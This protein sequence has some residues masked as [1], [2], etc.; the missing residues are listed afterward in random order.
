MGGYGSGRWG[1]GGKKTQVEE[2]IKW[3]IV[4]LKNYL[5]PGHWGTT[6]WM[7][8][9]RESGS[10]SFRVLG[11]EEPEAL[12]VSYTIG[13]RSGNPQD[14][15]YRVNLTTTPLPWGGVRYWFVCPLQGCGRRV[16]CLYLPPGSK[17]FG[18]R[19]CYDLSYESQQ[20]GNWS[21]GFYDRMALEMSGNYPGI[22]GKDVKTL[23]DGKQ[24][25]NLSSLYLEKALSHLK[26]YDRYEGYLSAEELC[27]QSG[28]TSENLIKLEETRL[29]VPDTK[30]GR[31]RPKLVGWGKK[32]AYLL[33]EG[34]GIEEIKIWS[35]ERWKSKNP[36]EWPP[37]RRVHDR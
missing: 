23:L 7:I 25:R 19:H 3:R 34:W 6:R 33:G 24:S 4:G 9:E 29:L 16:G 18:C 32:L 5:N 15:K 35:K 17:Y 2:C 27:Q 26:N 37:K 1:W 8:G 36:R 10:I 20:D 28:L 13:A 12:Q 14:F 22:T 31:Y 11:D 21:R 30:D